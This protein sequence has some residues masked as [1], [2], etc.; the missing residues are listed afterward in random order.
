M[1]ERRQYSEPF[2]RQALEKVYPRGSRGLGDEAVNAFCRDTFPGGRQLVSPPAENQVR[3]GSRT[4]R[5][6]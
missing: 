3:P 4:G 6:G 5:E 2:R 1:K